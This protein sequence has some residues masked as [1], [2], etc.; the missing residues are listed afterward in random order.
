MNRTDSKTLWNW[1]I[2]TTDGLQSAKIDI[3]EYEDICNR[4]QRE[5][6]KLNLQQNGLS[7]NDHSPSLKRPNSIS[8][9]KRLN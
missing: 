9:E 3:A 6:V 7:S 8:F 4:I 1:I 5:V 2:G